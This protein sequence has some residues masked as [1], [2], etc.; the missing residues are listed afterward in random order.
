MEIK[1]NDLID[2][3]IT[4]ADK[5]IDRTGDYDNYSIIE[6]ECCNLQKEIR[7][8]L[9]K[10]LSEQFEYITRENNKVLREDLF[11]IINDL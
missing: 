2:V 10:R 6:D 5:I 11:K 4:F 8:I 1:T 9:Y 3:A 7:S